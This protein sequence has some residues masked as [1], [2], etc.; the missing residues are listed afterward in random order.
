MQAFSDV[1]GLGAA[2]VD[3]RGQVF[4]SAGLQKRC[5][6]FLATR[7]VDSTSC[8]ACEALPP[9]PGFVGRA[10]VYRCEQGPLD[11]RVPLVVDGVLVADLIVGS[12]RVE[13]A[14]L[15]ALRAGPKVLAQVSG[16][17]V[18]AVEP[19]MLGE[20]RLASILR[21]V[22]ELG[23]AVA[24]AA[25]QQQRS[26]Q[27][28]F[29]G[30]VE[31][32]PDA[33]V[34]IDSA[35][36]IQLVNAQAERLFGWT[37][38]ELVG[39]AVEILVPKAVHA[40]HLEHR[41][42]YVAAPTL[43][44]MGEGRHLA[45]RHKSGREIPVE[46]GL[47]HFT[48]ESGTLS[49]CA[50]IRDVSDRRRLEGELQRQQFLAETALEL[51]RAGYWHVPLDGSGWYTSSP[52]TVAINGDPPREDLRYRLR[53]EWGA[54][55]E[56]ANPE[57]AE[58]AFANF[59]AA[60]EGT[61]PRYDA[62]YAYKRP[63]DG[64]IVW[65]HALG[66][67]VRDAE[68]RATDMFGVTQDITSFKALEFE[69]L[70]ARD[71][72]EAAT[73]AKSDFLANMSHEIRTPMNAIIGMSHLCLRTE[74]SS[75]QR[76][77]VSKIDGA[78]RNLLGIIN[79][80]LDFSKI[81]AGRLEIEEQPFELEAVLEQVSSLV[82]TRAQEKGLE[83]V[84]HADPRLPKA[85]I[86]DAL[87]LG[88]I[89]VNL[90]GN[91]VKFTEQG[92]IVVTITGKAE[93]GD[94]LR[95]ACSVRDTGIG[96]TAEQMSRLFQSFTQADA[97]TTR[98]FGGT[99][100]GL[101]ISKRLVEMM[102]GSIGVDSSMGVGSTF[103]FEVAVK[104]G[105]APAVV[106][107]RELTGVRC[108]VVDDNAS[109][110]QVM[111]EQLTSLRLR[112]EAAS[113]GPAAIEAVVSAQQVSDPFSIV[114]MDYRMPGMDGLATSRAILA[115]VERPP[116]IVMATAYGSDVLGEE[117]RRV[118]ID[119]YLV[120][121]ISPS[122]LFDAAMQ[123]LG[124][125]AHGVSRSRQAPESTADHRGLLGARVLLVEDNDINQQ[126]ARELLELVGMTVTVAEN[127]LEAVEGM[128]TEFDI[129]LMDVQM[130]V[131]DGY[132]A[133][134][135]ILA[136]PE[137]AAIPIVA[138]TANALDVDRA[139]ALEAG[140]S[141]HVA[142]PIEPEILYATLERLVPRGPKR[143]ALAQRASVDSPTLPAALPGIDMEGGLR[144][145]GG[146]G[147]LYRRL[148]ARF[149]E[150]EQDAAAR[151]EELLRRG[152]EQQAAQLAHTLKG[153]AA[154]LGMTSVHALASA[155]EAA[156][157]ARSDAGELAALRQGLGEVLS[158]LVS[159]LGPETEA[160]AP[161]TA[162][163]TLPAREA[164]L[165]LRSLLLLDDTE[166]VDLAERL[167]AETGHPGLLDVER[168]ARDF[169]FRAACER[170]DRLLSE[171]SA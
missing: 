8:V 167:A 75:K 59:A 146:N 13:S 89:L 123:A 29:R 64:R 98:R 156:L 28:Q 153:V 11:A 170:L 113:S 21:F 95:L 150:T 26:G 105:R 132:T 145:V 118:G 72:A 15:D 143:A 4:V 34:I 157:L 78:A 110:R 108:L 25:I 166:C 16:E 19:P 163:A 127:G 139:R 112:A 162:S 131:M 85:L 47:S 109:A 114:F 3:R 42:A 100:L 149:L 69:L 97:S 94:V 23:D 53:E 92:E 70:Q 41:A 74:L 49:I 63:I 154:N 45:A 111:V 160:Q 38:S 33:L 130:P 76:D 44:T 88:Q 171:V 124:A 17:S 9:A 161:T 133:T 31:A 81:E 99:G 116:R 87:R 129:V 144:R 37:R 12:F 80:I 56:A 96:M 84:L 20:A 5:A 55:V 10:R 141:D 32:A 43:R 51:T 71:A 46:I 79:E 103:R 121:P 134:G 148:L 119:G 7:S 147:A 128:S 165:R 52:R 93:E 115:A 117:A 50:A 48:T 102:G 14:G 159:G 101:T 1:V 107:A 106:D 77:Y 168:L 91:A 135:H 66:D 126:V 6:N 60:V 58:R 39:K 136:R 2:I 73:R 24:A 140:M 137:F 22:G 125:A 120:K 65:I 62:T 27:S 155:F 152:D 18:E 67:V 164:L 68:G 61:V 151:L 169:D 54:C 30:V 158:G 57:L 36:I 138:M 82:S 104:V 35:G 40:R 142:K 90:C 122:A 83:F 86:G